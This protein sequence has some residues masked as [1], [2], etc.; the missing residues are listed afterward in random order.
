MHVS[1]VSLIVPLKTHFSVSV[2]HSEGHVGG[3]EQQQRLLLRQ[4]LPQTFNHL[5]SFGGSLQTDLDKVNASSSRRLLRPQPQF[6]HFIL[7]SLQASETK[8]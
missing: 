2:G 1:S 5:R 6:P 4:L 7:V 3:H 8:W